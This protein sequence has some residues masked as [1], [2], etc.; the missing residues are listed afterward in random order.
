MAQRHSPKN[1]HRPEEHRNDKGPVD[2]TPILSTA[3]LPHGRNTVAAD[4]GVPPP[5]TART[6]G[7]SRDFCWPT[8][9]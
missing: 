9:A 5:R 6:T 4:S 1:H 3:A 7:P 8:R 2:G